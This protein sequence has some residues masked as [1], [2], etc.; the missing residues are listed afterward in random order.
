MNQKMVTKQESKKDITI[1]AKRL[2]LVYYFFTKKLI[3]EMG[4]EEAER[5]VK[6]VIEEYGS[7]CGERVKEK[8]ESLGHEIK[9]ENYGKGKD[10]PTLGWD[11]SLVESDGETM[12]YEFANCPFAEQWKELDFEKWGRLYCWIDQ[13]KYSAFD[14]RIQCV[15]DENVLDGDSTCMIRLVTKAEP[16]KQ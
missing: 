12:L 10:L 16:A 15:H 2:A 7:Y 3:E 8:V 4:E 13:A 1:M 14:D 11:I 9:A 6:D 5:I